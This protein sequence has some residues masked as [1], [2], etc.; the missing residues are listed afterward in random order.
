MPPQQQPQPSLSEL[1][2]L[3]AAALSTENVARSSAEARLL[4]LA[5]NPGC[6]PALLE[7]LQRA[8]QP[9]ERHL[10]AILL[11]RRIAAH[12]PSLP[13]ATREALKTALLDALALEPACVRLP[14]SASPPVS[15][16]SCRLS[17]PP[18][19]APAATSSRWLPT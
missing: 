3:L 14:F 17:A 7:L 1:P 19:A 2:A 12:W 4:L 16:A 5:K 15:L 9:T 11:R 6:V 18:F 8:A 13:A 10:A